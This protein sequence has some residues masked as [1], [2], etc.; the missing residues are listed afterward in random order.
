MTSSYDK[1][2]NKSLDGCRECPPR[3]ACEGAEISFIGSGCVE[4]GGEITLRQPHDETIEF[5]VDCP[6]NGKLSIKT[7]ESLEGGVD[8]YAN[9]KCNEDVTLCINNEWLHKFVSSRVCDGEL[10]IRTTDDMK[11]G[12]T[13]TANQCNNT[14]VVLSVNW[15]HF[16]A[17]VNGGI[18]LY[19][20]CWEV[21]WSE[22]PVC[23]DGGLVWE[24]GCWKLDKAAVNDLVDPP[25]AVHWDDIEGKP[26][27]FPACKEEG[28]E[29]GDGGD[30]DPDPEP[31]PGPPDTGAAEVCISKD[32]KNLKFDKD[33]C[34]EFTQPDD[35]DDEWPSY[36]PRMYGHIAPKG[37]KTEGKAEVT[38]A[39]P[40]PDGKP[41]V[42]VNATAFPKVDGDN[43]AW[44]ID[45]KFSKPIKTDRYEVFLTPG[46][47][48]YDHCMTYLKD[49]NAKKGFKVYMHDLENNV[50]INGDNKRADSNHVAAFSF[51]VLF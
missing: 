7:C 33:G 31:D 38:Y 40:G 3:K 23:P 6:G 30:P 50:S 44:E 37:E 14:S 51:M 41:C 45:L 46:D 34:L 26:D 18:H 5:H 43:T 35:G 8:F 9:S 19:Q 15:E 47:G 32:E 39:S 12:G 20:G 36:A 2:K 22:W 29:G 10:T 49:S 21:N 13:F 25:P 27:C 24:A 48:S 28:G 11:G 42:T 1:Y 4:G 16:P 17:C